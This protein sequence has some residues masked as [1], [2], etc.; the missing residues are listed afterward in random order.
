[1]TVA[2]AD[3]YT[4]ICNSL[5]RF[6]EDF[7]KANAPDAVYF[8]WDAHAQISDIPESDVIGPAGIGLANEGKITQVAFSYGLATVGDTNLFRLREMMS[9]LY[10]VLQPED[11]VP[12]YDTNGNRFSWIVVKSPVTIAPVSKS[13]VRAVQFISVMG[14]LDPHAASGA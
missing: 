2:P 7:R 4:C 14:L 5:I 11:I 3:I 12:V 13:E 10:G 9:K 6:G 8:D 1:M